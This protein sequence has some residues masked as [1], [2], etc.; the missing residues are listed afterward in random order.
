[1]Q[2]LAGRQMPE[3]RFDEQTRK[4]RCQRT[5]VRK[6]LGQQARRALAEG[7]HCEASDPESAGAEEEEEVKAR[8]FDA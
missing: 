6:M 1:M 8:Y 2:G 4:G 5:P 7:M 3:V